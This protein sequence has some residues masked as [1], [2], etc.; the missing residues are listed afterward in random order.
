MCGQVEQGVM[1]G[2]CSTHGTEDK[3][4]LNSG[5]KE[6]ALKMYAKVRQ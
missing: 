6:T 4:I 3:S 5:G 2:T 1:Y